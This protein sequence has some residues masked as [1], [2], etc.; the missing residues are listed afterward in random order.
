MYG[1]YRLTKEDCI[2]GQQFDDQIALCGAPIEDHR[3]SATGE[4]ETV[5]GY[6]E[7]EGWRLRR[8]VRNARA[9]EP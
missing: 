8:T 3:Q 9:E 1:E 2:S 5:W 6:V 7:Q 4:E